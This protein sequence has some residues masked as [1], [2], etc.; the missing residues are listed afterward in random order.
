MATGLAV[1]VCCQALSAQT[2]D[3]NFCEDTA[4]CVPSVSGMPRS[5]ALEFSYETVTQYP[6]QANSGLSGLP[7]LTNGSADEKRFMVKVK[8]PVYIGESWKV[9]AGFQYFNEEFSFEGLDDPNFI[10]GDVLNE[11][12]LKSIGGRIYAVK[13]WRGK[14]Y[15]ALRAGADLNGDYT[16][17]SQP[18]SDYLRI[19]VAPVFGLKKDANTLYGFGL[20]WGYNFGRPSLYPFLVYNKTFNDRWGLETML[21]AKAAVRVNFSEKMMLYSGVQLEGASY[22]IDPQRPDL[23]RYSSLRLQKSELRLFSNLE[24]EIHDFLWVQ[25][26]A[27]VRFNYRFALTDNA[28]INPATLVEVSRQPAFYVRTGIFLV[29]PRK[30]VE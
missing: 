24:R 3:I 19:S 12:N 23:E 21:P 1:S 30:F 28:I 13:A 20:A 8:F 10:V 29:P 14:H 6:Y 18:K 5:K 9:A 16:S 26:E 7:A 11:R 2:S 27:G 17:E 22:T 15:F 25:F 4:Y